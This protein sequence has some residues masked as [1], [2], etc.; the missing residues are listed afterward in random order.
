M[1]NV[2]MAE[3]V[4]KLDKTNWQPTKLGEL[5]TEISKRVDNPNESEYD[6][7][8]GL[9]NFVSGDIKIKSW[10][11]TKT[12]VS[13]AKAFEKGD[14]LFARRN[15]YLRRASMVDF[16]GCCSGDAFVLRENHDKVVPGFLAFLLN[17]DALWDYANSNAAGTM[18]KRVKWRDLAEYEFLLP[19]KEQQ[20]KLAELLWAMDEV[21]EKENEVLD[22]LFLNLIVNEKKIFTSKNYCVL[23]SVILNTL[24]GGTP[25]TKKQEFYTN[26]TIPWL[27]TKIIEDDQIEI[28]EK[29]ITNDA[30]LN[31]A[32]KVL[33]QGNIVAGTRVGVGKF[34][35][36]LCDISFSQDVT[37]LMIDHSKVNIDF[38][39]YQLNSIVF[40]SRIKPFLR[41]TTI[42]GILKDDLL[43][44]KIYLPSIEKQ[45]EL[46]KIISDLK[47]SRDLTKSK[48]TS[49]KALQ[50]SLINQVF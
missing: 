27:T 40:Q 50:K 39:V 23:K 11:T 42:K 3:K 14:I 48:I 1:D 16:D 32:A 18:S 2:V 17:S 37:G 36:N 46:R 25:N 22:N 26:G 49:S 31:S 34:S 29:L 33:P 24:S 21:I 41:G 30:V 38:L 15:A 19:T 10:E 8:V 4:L 13:S 47:N 9:G 12:L 7:F 45:L 5:A 44:M 43:N 35:I 28:G 20:A 6:R